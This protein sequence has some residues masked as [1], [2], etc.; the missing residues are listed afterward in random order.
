MPPSQYQRIRD[1]IKPHRVGSRT[2]SAALLAWFLQVVWRMDDADID[3]AI[4]D[5]GGDKGIDALV[6]E[7]ELREIT[8]LQSKYRKS[9]KAGQGD[10][11]LKNLVGAG[12]YFE[13]EATIDQLLRAK[14]NKELRDLITR[15]DLKAKV[16]DGAHVT[17]LVF[18]TN[19]SLDDAGRDYVKAVAA[20]TGPPLEVWDQKKLGPV[21]R[22]TKRP[23]LRRDEVKLTG[24]PSP[25]FTDLGSAAKMAVT[26][27]PAKQLVD[28]PGIEDR[29]LFDPNVRLGLGKTRINKELDQTVKDPPQHALF[30]A[31]H[32]G[33]TILTN[34]LKVRGRTVRL[35]GIAVVNGCQSLLSLFENRQAL[36][37]D[38]RVL[39]RVVEVD[40]HSTLPEDITYR[41]NNQNSVDIRDQRSR[42]TV[43]RDLQAE[44]K[45]VFGSKFG[46]EIRRGEKV[47][48][49][50]VL[51][52]ERAAQLIMAIYL[53]ES[54]NAVRKVALFDDGYRR[55]FSRR[56]DAYKL[57]LLS[58]IDRSIEGIRD[59]LR[60]DLTSSFASVRFALVGLLADILRLNKDGTELL[61]HPEVWLPDTEIQVG[62]KL[63]ELAEEV[64]G[65][66]NFFVEDEE[67]QA[68]KEGKTFDPKVA[69]KSQ[70]AVSRAQRE[71]KTA[72]RRQQRRAKD[73]FFDVE[74]N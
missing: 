35:D 45:D 29:S 16:A 2:E 47:P 31:Y 51:T 28:L 43:Q 15:T 63:A 61:A 5:G 7:D 23:E 26:L 18:V 53:H 57:Y 32:N 50:I 4:C 9:A 66:L 8:I 10:K 44:V 36:T 6:V 3:V 37:S 56:I 42:D 39:V 59:E 24:S 27:V 30:P 40:A 22:R 1:Q 73:F 17:R 19:G 74:P 21:A 68:A 64:A 60:D 20:G 11:D 49:K 48:A 72:A 46:Y 52:N 65:S 71:V 13:S 34:E 67:R 62:E 25:I 33:L 41:T 14:P 69:F 12:K 38:L 70:P 55:I 54:W 58:M